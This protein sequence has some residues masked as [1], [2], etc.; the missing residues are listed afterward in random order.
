MKKMTE[1]CVQE[2]FSGESMARMKYTILSEVAQNAGLENLARLFRAIAYSEEVH[3]TN[4]VRQLGLV[5]KDMTE[6]LE[7]LI[8]GETYEIE[9]MYPAFMAVAEHQAEKGAHQSFRYAIEAEKIHADMEKDAKETVKTGKDLSI[10]ALYVCPV[11]G[12][13]HEGT[14]PDRCPICNT[15][16]DK[17]KKF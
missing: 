7:G 17:F 12:Y 15:A 14:P 3:A 11:C 5:H 1:R 16:K 2:A 9:E 4:H 13:T 6:N 10:S 8:Q